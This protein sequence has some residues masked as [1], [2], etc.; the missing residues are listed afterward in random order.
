[1]SSILQ[2][3]ASFAVNTKYEALPEPVVHE[4]K[5]IL[6]DSIGCA[7][8][9]LTTDKGKMSVALAKMLGGPPEATIIGMSDKVSRC[10]AAFANGELILALDYDALIIPGAHVPPHVIP[11]VLATA[12]SVNASGKEVIL[13]TV[14]AHEIASR[15]ASALNTFYRFEG[16]EGQNVRWAH[17]YGHAPSNFGAA[18]GTGRMLNLNEEKMLHALGIAGHLCQVPTHIK[19][20]FSEPRPMVKYGVPGWQ[21]TGAIIASLLAQMGYTG[22]T[23]V[24]DTE[25]GFWRFAGFEEWHPERITEDIGNTWKFLNVRYKRYP[26]CS[27]LDTVLNC[28]ITI[29][30]QHHL[31]PEDIESVEAFLH[32]TVELPCFTNREVVDIVDAQFGVAYVFAVAAHRVRLGIEWQD[33][34]TMRDPK[35]LEFM[36]KVSYHRHPEYVKLHLKNPSSTIGLVEVVAKG[37][38]FREEKYSL[39]FPTADAIFTDEDLVE[40]FRHNASRVLTQPKIEEVVKAILK[41]EKIG[42]IAELMKQVTL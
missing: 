37:K 29:I 20:S 14:L 10:G 39:T 40:K 2:E 9:A 4:A 11:A 15:V 8:A 22:D 41:L 26:C 24:F 36:K 19:F 5:R 17:R 3:L 38:T 30:D 21:S 27:M 23:T 1:M 33:W 28:F 42:N 16:T 7:L 34:E 31:M 35:I 25:Y 6:L 13:G 32:P 18:A 12:E